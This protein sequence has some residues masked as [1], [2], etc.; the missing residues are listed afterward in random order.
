M[1]PSVQRSKKFREYLRP[2]PSVG[3][4]AD[5]VGNGQHIRMNQQKRCQRASAAWQRGRPA[6]HT[7]L[8]PGRTSSPCRRDNDNP[9]TPPAG[10]RG[11]RMSLSPRNTDFS[12]CLHPGGL[13]ENKASAPARCPDG[14]PA[15]SQSQRLAT[16]GPFIA[17]AQK[18]EAPA[19]GLR[20]M[21]Q[22]RGRGIR[23]WL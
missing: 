11:R 19:A 8:P 18:N 13:A 23:G 10:M 20:I 9:Y 7:S 6:H 1:P 15:P 5:S 16:G 3:A 22:G 14:Q 2:V 12:I 4:P 17:Q 21:Q